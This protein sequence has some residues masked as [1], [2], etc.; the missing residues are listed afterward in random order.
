MREH[1]FSVRF[2]KEVTAKIKEI[3]KAEDRSRNYIINKLVKEALAERARKAQEAQ[4]E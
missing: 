1:P 2:S 3:C 4:R